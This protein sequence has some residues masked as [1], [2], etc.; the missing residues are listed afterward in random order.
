MTTEANAAPAGEPSATPDAAAVAAAAALAAKP[1]VDP[2]LTIGDAPAG[3]AKPDT[4]TEGVVQYEPTGDIGLD[5]SLEFIGK[6]GIAGTHPAMVAA[7]KGDFAMLEGLLAGLG[8]KAKGFEKYLNLAKQSREVTTKAAADKLAKDQ[9]IVHDAVGGKDQWAEISK[10]AGMN[11]E[12]A[13]KEAVN[14]ALKQGG[15]VAKVM[16]QWLSGQY[17]KAAGTTVT[18]AQVVKDGAGGKSVGT[19]PMSAAE[20]ATAVQALRQ[21]VG[22]NLDTH[23]EY[24]ALQQRRSAAMAAG[25]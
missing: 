4:S 24:K 9:S 15:L 23:P 12:P 22:Y 11:A 18:P 2:G 19:G 13:E 6:L 7:D 16:A 1:A 10:W 17:A 5:L 25:R 21:K 14:A 20:Y 8:D 3:E